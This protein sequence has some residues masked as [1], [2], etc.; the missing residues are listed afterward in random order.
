MKIEVNQYFN[1]LCHNEKTKHS[2]SFGVKT[3]ILIPSIKDMTREQI[4]CIWYN[5]IDYTLFAKL[6]LN[7]RRQCG[8]L[9][10]SVLYNESKIKKFVYSEV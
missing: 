10:T 5:N 1:N 9:S 6:E 3:R 4:D 8:V 7:R 2:V